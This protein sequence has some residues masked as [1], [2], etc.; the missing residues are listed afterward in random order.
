MLD[1][2][3]DAK[4]NILMNYTEV[5][6]ELDV[7]FQILII[8]KRLDVL[9]YIDNIKELNIKNI[10][11]NKMN[12]FYEEYMKDLKKLLNKANIYETKYYLVFSIDVTKEKEIESIE[13][14]IFR[15][16]KVGCYVSKLR[17]VDNIKNMLYECIN[18]EH[19]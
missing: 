6:K 1:Y 15:L 3:K 11:K 19:I 10:S 9:K 7:G 8:N 5:L 4:N 14:C 18:K 17:G 16:N 13:N 2:S 12:I